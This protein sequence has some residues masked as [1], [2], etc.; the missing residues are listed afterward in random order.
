MEFKL[1]IKKKDIRLVKDICQQ[2]CDHSLY[3]ERMSVNIR[4]TKLRLKK[5]ALWKIIINCLLTTQ[6]RSGKDSAINKFLRSKKYGAIKLAVVLGK[7][8]RKFHINKQL[9]SVWRANVIS[10]HA[11]SILEYLERTNWQLLYEIN[12]KSSYKRTRE[13]ER[14]FAKSIAEN[15]ELI[16]LGP[17]QA[18]NLLQMTGYSIYEIPIDSRITDW[19][20]AND[21]FPFKLS[22]KSLSDNNFYGFL[23]DAIIELCARAGVEPCLFDAAVFS[24]FE[25]AAGN[26]KEYN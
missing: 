25:S 22:S 7:K 4:H 6:Q 24:S 18:R 16:G 12:S 5:E 13:T 15:K 19:L 21:I 3:K 20:N 2:Q 10:E 1:V 17:K 8:D 23:N 9:N 26:G 11:A 14:E